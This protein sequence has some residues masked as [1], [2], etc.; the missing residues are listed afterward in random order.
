MYV[1]IMPRPQISEERIKEL[2]ELCEPYF[3]VDLDR[4]GVDTQLEILLE[5]HREYRENQNRVRIQ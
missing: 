3:T 2:E 5:K 4:V 1:M